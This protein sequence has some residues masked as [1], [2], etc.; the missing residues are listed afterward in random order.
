VS[1]PTTTPAAEPITITFGVTVSEQITTPQA[2]PNI[3]LIDDGLGNE[4]QRQAAVIANGYT[5]CLPGAGKQWG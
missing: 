2:I 5:G 1:A 3:A 4:W